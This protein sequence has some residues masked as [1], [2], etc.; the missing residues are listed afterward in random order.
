MFFRVLFYG[1]DLVLWGGVPFFLTSF[2]TPSPQRV[3]NDVHSS[4]ADFRTYLVVLSHAFATA[5]SFCW[6]DVRQTCLRPPRRS[7]PFHFNYPRI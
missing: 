1:F 3:A 2:S 6:P 5:Q 7:L 4:H